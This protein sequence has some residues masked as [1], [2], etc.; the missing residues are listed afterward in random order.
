METCD[1]A[2]VGAGMVGAACANLLAKQGF[3]VHVIERQLPTPYH[4]EQPLDLRVSAIN[5]ASMTLLKDAGAWSHIQQMRLC[6]YRILETW[7]QDGF[8]TRFD[9][10]DL[11]LSELGYIVEN[12]LIQ[13]ALLQQLNS[14]SS[15]HISSPAT[16]SSITQHSD[17]ISLLFDDKS[18]LSARWLLACDG[19]HSQIRQLAGIG[20]SCFDY[21][22]HCLLINIDTASVQQD[23]TW[24]QFTPKGPR[25]FLPLP[26]QR[27]SLVWYDTPERIKALLSMNNEQLTKQVKAHFPAKLG[28]FNI[29]A[30]ASFSLVRRHANNYHAGRIILLGDA[31]HTINP[32]AGQGVN[33]GFKDVACWTT[34]L[35]NA[36][37]SWQQLSLAKQYEKQRRP[38]NL[39]MQ[40]SMDLCYG[41][42]SN[43]FIP[44]KIARNLAL[45]LADRSGPL[46][47]IALRY[48]LG[49]I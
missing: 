11:S 35:E 13:L 36:G 17:K 20:L 41:I 40:S 15:V 6:P 24:Q 12:R 9:A 2:I 1:I 21:R 4:P 14:H 45:H 18:R 8:T 29:T 28:E 7:E 23:I 5:Q 31:A 44:L 32:L 22:Q 49:L 16:V 42:F 3:S 26:D 34:L 27:G 46:K 19:A 30:K 48:A 37:D 10:A 47:K 43:D 39:L 38:A 33:L 25:A